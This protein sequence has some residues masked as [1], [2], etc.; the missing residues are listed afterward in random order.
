MDWVKSETSRKELQ[1]LLNKAGI[2]PN[3]ALIILSIISTPL[4]KL[5]VDSTSTEKRYSLLKLKELRKE[6]HWLVLP[7][8]Y[9]TLNY[10]NIIILRYTKSRHPIGN[11][12]DQCNSG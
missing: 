3:F 7:L 8:L 10:K 5:D 12:L 4:K 1:E 6:E 9:T 2:E 11:N